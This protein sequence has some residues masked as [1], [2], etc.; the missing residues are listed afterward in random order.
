MFGTLHDTMGRLDHALVGGL[1]CKATWS[2]WHARRLRYAIL[3]SLAEGNAY[4]PARRWSG[5]LVGRYDLPESIRSI[6][7]P[8]HRIGEFWAEHLYPGRPDP[9]AGDGRGV[10]SG[11]PIAGA[12]DRVRRSLAVLWRDSRLGDALEQYSRSGAVLGDAFLKVADDPWRMRVAIQAVHPGTVREFDADLSG[13]CRGYVIERPEPDPEQPAAWPGEPPPTATYREEAWR[14]GRHAWFATYRD[15]E[16]YD[17]RAYAPGQAAVGPAWSM[18][19]GFVPLV[20]VEHEADPSGWGRSALHAALQRLM[21]CDA[22]AS[23]LCDQVYKTVRAPVYFEGGRVGD[24]DV[25]SSGEGEH[26]YPILGG[27]G[28]P[29]MLVAPLDLADAGGL[30]RQLLGSLERDHPELALDD[31]GAG[32]SGEARREARRRAEAAVV[33]RR[34]AY[35]EGLVRAQMMAL[36]MGGL[37]EYPGYEWVRLDSY[38]RGELDHTIGERPVFATDERERLQDE[39]QRGKSVAALTAGGVPLRVAMRRAG[40]DPAEIEEA[41][42]ERDA[43]AEAAVARAGRLGLDEGVGPGIGHAPRA[44]PGPDTSGVEHAF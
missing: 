2:A 34:A 8:A 30:L 24:V 20:H 16:P 39:E 25:A 32:A 15:G 14:E 13:N 21:E 10:P 26:A 19:Y 6:C 12:T 40:F 36:S 22:L 18:P 1:G 23:R 44:L 5:A 42:R 29:H 27:E 4:D 3:G 28:K 17:W 31:V 37:G 11:V 35:D 41:L 38:G 43:E 7:A 9:D 33:R